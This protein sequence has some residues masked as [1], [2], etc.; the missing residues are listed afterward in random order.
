MK[1]VNKYFKMFTLTA[2]LERLIYFIICFLIIIHLVAC[3]WGLLGQEGPEP[4]E[5]WVFAYN[6]LD[7]TPWELF[8]ISF[9]WAIT[10]LTTVGYGD[11]SP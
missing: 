3:F 10:T 8:Q 9:Y 1:K 11:I 4:T 7:E 5:N 6:F 2:G